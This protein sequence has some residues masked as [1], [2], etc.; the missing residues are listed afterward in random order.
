MQP[1]IIFLSFILL[2]CTSHS[3]NAESASANIKISKK[4]Q[5]VIREVKEVIENLESATFKPV[6]RGWDHDY[7]LESN[8]GMLNTYEYLRSLVSYAQFQEQIGINIFKSGPHTVEHLDLTNT[9]DFGHYNPRFVALFHTSLKKLM[10]DEQFIALTHESVNQYALIQ[11]L[12][13]LQEIYTYIQE[14]EAEFMDITQ[15]YQRR[16]SLNKWP[17]EGY[18]M[19]MPEGL[20][21]DYYWNWSETAYHFWVR[22]EVDG[23]KELWIRVIDDIVSAYSL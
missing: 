1:L 17:T 8:P 10:A 20:N 23:T 6:R 9:E 3:V 11:K 7:G 22:R 4:E 21:S 12:K 15:E 19:Y 16:L 2:F 18:R 13:Q 14:N 5:S